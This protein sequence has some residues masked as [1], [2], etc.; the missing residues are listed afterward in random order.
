MTSRYRDRTTYVVG[1]DP[2]PSTGLVVLRGDG[3]RMHVQQG[4]PSQVVDDLAL[5][6]PFLCVPSSDVLVGCERY[7]QTGG[8]TPMSSQPVPQRVIGVVETVARVHGWA[9]HLQSPSDA[10]S[11]VPNSL[12]RDLGL[13]T[14]GRDVERRDADD[15][16]DATRHALTV[17]AHHRASLFDRLLRGTGV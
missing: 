13:W 10:K 1:V 15:A 16:N 7:V 2:G 3:F 17:L 14:T 8:P 6:F 4:T 9:F 11:L 12:L 5:R